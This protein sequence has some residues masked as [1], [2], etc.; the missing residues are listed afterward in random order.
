MVTMTIRNV[1]EETR[2]ALRFRAAKH[3]VS[4]EQEVRNIL[5]DVTRS[6]EETVAPMGRLGQN[7]YRSIRELVEPYGGFE[8]EV[9]PRNKTMRDPPTFD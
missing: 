1:D 4:V 7:W 3:G 9:P 8:L 5:K 2:Q 6:P